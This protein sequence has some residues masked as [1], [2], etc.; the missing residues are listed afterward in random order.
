ML[1]SRIISNIEGLNVSI[2]DCNS[3]L[4]DINSNALSTEVVARLWESY[5]R[6]STY[7]LS[8][9]SNLKNNEGDEEEEEGE[10]EKL[11]EG[12]VDES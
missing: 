1:L 6:N 9:T 5:L 10:E 8:V 12:E 4:K 3:I 11:E 2:N 7:N